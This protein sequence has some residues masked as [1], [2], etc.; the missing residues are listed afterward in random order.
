MDHQICTGA[1][2]ELILLHPDQKI[3]V[4][5][6]HSTDLMI[7]QYVHGQKEKAPRSD[8][9]NLIRFISEQNVEES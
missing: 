8:S 7:H 4:I 1:G 2:N 6:Q 5:Y 9:R 3:I